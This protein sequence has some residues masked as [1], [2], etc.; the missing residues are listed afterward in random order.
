MREQLLILRG[1][2]LIRT[3]AYKQVVKIS[4]MNPESRFSFTGAKRLQSSL[5]RHPTATHIHKGTQVQG[6]EFNR[7]DWTLDTENHFTI[8]SLSTV[9]HFNS[10]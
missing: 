7:R 5:K 8:A 6:Q 9:P 3:T 10:F 1:T 2:L 4:R